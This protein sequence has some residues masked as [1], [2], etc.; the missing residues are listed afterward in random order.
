MTISR[1]QSAISK[2]TDAT[3]AVASGA[4]RSENIPDFEN[5]I[6]SVFAANL[7]MK[8]LKS[9][10]IVDEMTIVDLEALSG[11]VSLI[12]STPNQESA[13]LL[14]EKIALLISSITREILQNK[15]ELSDRLTEL[16]QKQSAEIR[17]SIRDQLGPPVTRPAAAAA[18]V[19]EAPA[20][21]AASES[22][23]PTLPVFK[24]FCR[25]NSNLPLVA[26]L[27]RG[28]HGISD[29]FRLCV[30]KYENSFND[31]AALSDSV[32]TAALKEDTASFYPRL[33]R[34]YAAIGSTLDEV[35]D[36]SNKES[37]S[38]DQKESLITSLIGLTEKF[39]AAPEDPLETLNR[40]MESLDD[41]LQL[42]N[43]LS[44]QNND[45]RDTVQAKLAKIL[46]T[47]ESIRLQQGG[48]IL[49]SER[50]DL[51][52]PVVA[53]FAAIMKQPM[54]QK[55]Q[56]QAQIELE[57]IVLT[58][59][60]GIILASDRITQS[61]Q[62]SIAAPKTEKSYAAQFCAILLS[63]WNWITSCFS[64][65]EPITGPLNDFLKEQATLTSSP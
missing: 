19:V 3:T 39:H 36:M 61:E 50:Q 8:G 22:P 7:Q 21:A 55:L 47:Q 45:N 56:D 25:K 18:A 63:L 40:K 48:L 16:V 46:T 26:Q 15:P 64:R 14:F 31:P 24:G 11:C 10:V 1:L 43:E 34:L 38:K 2:L 29:S 52:S 57:S 51:R 5:T 35:R 12:S 65:K 49:P 32:Y 13:I 41:L 54:P 6:T 20:A 59:N 62:S 53:E 58:H 42:L 30:L 33:N 37:S 4:S 27:T 23:S 60:K 28:L 17:N 44:D 9:N